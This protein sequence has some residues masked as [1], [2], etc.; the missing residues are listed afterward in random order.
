LASAGDAGTVIPPPDRSIEGQPFE[1]RQTPLFNPEGVLVSLSPIRF[2]VPS[3]PNP[4]QRIPGAVGI[5]R[6]KARCEAAQIPG[7]SGRSP[8]PDCTDRRNPPLDMNVPPDVPTVH[9]G[10]LTATLALDA[11]SAGSE[12][13]S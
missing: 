13:R 5:W 10:E 9:C 6:S 11:Y 1:F 8:S 12:I 2:T 7:P 3:C 4:E